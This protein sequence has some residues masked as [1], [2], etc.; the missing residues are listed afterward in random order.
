MSEQV[1]TT[2]WAFTAYE[3]QWHLFE[4][5]PPGVAE[6]AW[7]QEI[8]KSTGRPHYQGWIRTQRQ[9][10]DAAMRKLLPGVHIEQARDWNQLKQY[11]VKTD[12]AVPGTQVHGVNEIVNNQTGHRLSMAAA[13]SVLARAVTN[14]LLAMSKLDGAVQEFWA[15]TR[16]ILEVDPNAVGLFTQPQY[17]RAWVNTRD[18]WLRAVNE[19]TYALGGLELVDDRDVVD[20]YLSEEQEDQ[21]ELPEPVSYKVF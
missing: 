6:W 18:V 9:M 20:I 11:C 3:N 12:T 4:T 19:E 17:Q 15:A 8:C 5:M 7:Q 16:D 14:Q 13:M 21:V 10:R 2:R 1:K